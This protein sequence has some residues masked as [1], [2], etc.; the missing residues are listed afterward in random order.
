[1]RT[2]DQIKPEHSYLGGKAYNLALLH[3]Q[4][5]RVPDGIILEEIPQTPDSWD[6]LLEWW[7]RNDNRPLAVR[8]SAKAEDSN[9]TSFAGQ[10]SSFLNVLSEEELRQAVLDCFQSINNKAS[11]VYGDH[12]IGKD[13]D[14]GMNVVI[15]LMVDAK[16]AGVYFSK[17]PRGLQKSWIL[18]AIEG[19]GEDLVSGKRTPQIYSNEKYPESENAHLS[20]EQV[21]EIN[22]MGQSVKQ[23]LDTEIDIEW[24][25]DKKDRLFLLQ[26]RPITTIDPESDAKDVH[27]IGEEELERLRKTHSEKT[28]WDGQTFAEWNG[29]PTPATY[30]LWSKAFSPN[31]SFGDAL[32]QLGYLSFT[33]HEF[34]PQESI[35]EMV[36]GRAYINLEKLG[37][38]FF[39]PIPYRIEPYPRPHLKFD[40]KKINATTILRTP[41]SIYKMIQVGWNLSTS[42]KKWIGHCHK[43]LSMFKSKMDRP[44]DANLYQSW[45][46]DKL[47]SRLEKEV[48]IFS[49]YTLVNPFT[50]VVLTE[51][52]MSSLI[53]I[54]NSVFEKDE[55]QQRLR[56]WMAY[57]LQTATSEMNRYFKKA[58]AYPRF[59]PFFMSR[60]GHRGP[61]ELDLVS[62][63]WIEIG[64]KSFYSLKP[65]EYEESKAELFED[66]LEVIQEIEN[67]D[68]FKR[69]IIKQEWL[70]LKE[71]LELREQWK[72]ELL[73]PYAHIR[74]ILKEIGI[75]VGLDEN[76]FWLNVDEI[77]SLQTK[78]GLDEIE[79]L[80]AQIKKR[81]ERK[82]DMKYFSFPQ[83]VSMADIE[84]TLAGEAGPQSDFLKGEPLSPGLVQGKVLIVEDPNEVDLDSI[85]EN[86]ILVA[87]STDPGWTP[88]FTKVKGIVVEK[89]G[90]LS[91]CAILA[92]E[93]HLPAVS[94]IFQCHRKLKNGQ[95]I[96]LDGNYG[97]INTK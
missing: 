76:I 59:R 58:C 24:A 72:M 28:V 40:Y 69:S 11:Q 37:S 62:K 71:L 46:N 68:S 2:F 89:G 39:G 3:N 27:A 9:Q 17:D 42:R 12:F 5:F 53:A 35:L 7:K 10:N 83:I 15:Q 54:L 36:F 78:E 25:I 55:A 92:R 20:K 34:S 90:V 32:K 96:W 26:A 97:R 31:Q 91:H 30:S 79:S 66:K 75:R 29:Y 65:E 67:I 22:R 13:R 70:M 1:M 77:M 84:K 61:G 33:N 50:L 21:D 73:K 45:S 49:K 94:G 95:T 48:H 81:K 47:F 63:R 86:T 41:I 23:I 87:E 44:I 18:E 93:L 80:K 6:E 56:R 57:G 16:A 64:E 51:S 85:E 4:G 82:S 38:L 74:F 19:L 14:R 8:S 88:L 43:E 60:Y 52:T